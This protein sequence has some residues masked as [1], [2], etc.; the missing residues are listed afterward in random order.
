MPD[1]LTLGD[2]VMIG[3]GE[4]GTVLNIDGDHVYVRLDSGRHMMSAMVG[5]L[6]KI[7]SDGD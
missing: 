4:L 3:D 7:A 6:K 5:S 1:T 2:R